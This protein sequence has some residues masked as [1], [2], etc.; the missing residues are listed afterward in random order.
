MKS[1]AERRYNRRF[2]PV[3]ALYVVTILAVAWIFKHYHP[4]GILMYLLAVLPASPIL[5]MIGVFGVY[6]SEEKDEFL[7]MVMMLSSLWATGIVLALA[8]FWGFV[9][10]FTPTQR[11]STF[12][13]FWT[14]CV[15]FGLA[16]PLVRRR[17][18]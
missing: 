4:Q 13:I 1:D 3:M 8:T 10:F 6:I 7:R 17:Y 15:V 18:R 12:W 14:W 5:G 16:Q 9:E 11:L 2:W